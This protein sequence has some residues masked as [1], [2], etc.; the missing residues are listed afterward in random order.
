[1]KNVTKIGGR[2]QQKDSQ[3]IDM[4]ELTKTSGSYYKYS[5][6]FKNKDEYMSKQ[7]EETQQVNER[8]NKWKPQN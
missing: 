5:Q 3:M 8:G 2:K 6:K 7:V 1:M 4:L